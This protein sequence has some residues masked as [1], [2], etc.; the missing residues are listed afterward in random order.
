MAAVGPLRPPLSI[1]ARNCIEQKTSPP[2]PI[3]PSAPTLPTRIM[4][5]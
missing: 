2:A 3:L 4:P 1:D 5:P